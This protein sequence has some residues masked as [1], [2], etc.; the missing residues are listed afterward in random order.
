MF[1]W[2]EIRVQVRALHYALGHQKLLWYCTRTGGPCDILWFRAMFKL[3]FTL[4]YCKTLS[5]N[6]KDT[7]LLQRVQVI[8]SLSST[9]ADYKEHDN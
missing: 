7:F 2:I 3:S 4:C 8:Q 1:V 9:T 5:P 6:E